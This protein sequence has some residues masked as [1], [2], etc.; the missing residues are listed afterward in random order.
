M[1]AARSQSRAR[2]QPRRRALTSA[3]QPLVG[4][5]EQ[6]DLVINDHTPAESR[7][8]SGRGSERETKVGMQR[9]GR[10]RESEEKVQK[11]AEEVEK[12]E[13]DRPSPLPHP[14]RAPRRPKAA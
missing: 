7:Y 9:G 4:R 12:E 3:A 1:K 2:A 14:S 8:G 13:K 6:T 10:K 5:D 11:D